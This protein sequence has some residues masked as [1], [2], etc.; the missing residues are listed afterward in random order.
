K[1][2][3]S[4]FAATLLAS[5]PGI[6]DAIPA[7]LLSSYAEEPVKGKLLRGYMASRSGDVLLLTAPG[8]MEYQNKG[9]THGSGFSYDSRVPFLF[10]GKG[11]LPG[12]S[13]RGVAITDIAPSISLILGIQFPN[14]C[15]G[16][17]LSEM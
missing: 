17:P 8:W 16:S 9:T 7:H 6:Q 3:V 5:F 1:E 2:E 12:K 15:T 14:A 11:I 13:S 10:M 4:T